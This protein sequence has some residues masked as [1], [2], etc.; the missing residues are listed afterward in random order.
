MLAKLWQIL[1]GLVLIINFIQA[2]QVTDKKENKIFLKHM[3]KYL[4][5]AYYLI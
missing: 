3:V 5:I 2:I 1:Q 4:R